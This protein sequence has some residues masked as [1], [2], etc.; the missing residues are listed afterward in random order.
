VEERRAG[1]DGRDPERRRP[2]SSRG[3]PTRDAGDLRVI[4]EHKARFGV[5]SI[6][7]A[8]TGAQVQDRLENLLRL[9]GRG[10][11]GPGPGRS[12]VRVQAPNVLLVADFTYG[13]MATDGHTYPAFVERAIR[14]ARGIPVTGGESL[15]GKDNRPF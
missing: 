15:A 7:S 9:G 1:A 12:P 10:T 13:A 2:V 4:A 14:Q 5:A 6:C 8:L 3:R 11:V